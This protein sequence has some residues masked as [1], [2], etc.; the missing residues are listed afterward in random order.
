VL[1]VIP[2]FWPR[3]VTVSSSSALLYSNQPATLAG[4]A[5]RGELLSAQ[6][7]GL[8]P[9]NPGVDSGQPFPANSGAVVNS[10]VQVL[11]NGRSAEVL[12][13]VG[14]PGAIDLYQV[15]FRMPPDTPQG[16]ATIQFTTAWIPGSGVAIRVR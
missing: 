4:S 3:I 10:P 2:M 7:S 11:V 5:M 1:Q 9:T 14:I 15:D 13:A 8:G 12:R 6:V 16:S